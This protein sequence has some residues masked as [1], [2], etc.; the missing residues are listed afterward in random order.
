MAS[1]LIGL[2]FNTLNIALPSIVRHFHAG[3]LAA[4]W[5]LLAFMLANTVLIVVFGRFADMFGRRAMYLAGLAA[6]TG[7]SLLLGFA[8][9]AW[10]V[11]GLRVLQAAGG[12]MLLAN[13]AAI[14][15][16]VFPREQLGRAMG[17]YTAGF[18]IAQLAGP[19]LGGFLVDNFGWRWVFWFSVPVGVLCLLWGTAVLRPVEPATRERGIDV[20]GNTLVL[21]GLGGLLFGLSQVSD[22]GWSSPFVLGGIVVFVALLPVFLAVERRSPHPVVDTT[23]FRDRPF[24]LGLLATFLD[25][26]ART[27]AVL[28]MALFFQA[29]QGDDP[30]TAGLK[31]LPMAAVAVVASMGSGF[32]Q[33]RIDARTLT[34]FAAGLTTLGLVELLLT[35]SEGMAYGWVAAGLMLMGAGAGL[36]L[37]SNATALLRGLPSHRLGIVNAMRLMVLNTG[38]VVSTALAFPTITAP[39]P[40]PLREHVFAGTLAQVSEPGVH[41]LVIGYRYALAYMAVLA[42]LTVLTCLAGREP[43][44]RSAPG[45]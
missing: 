10:T 15:T 17:I 41:R 16:D 33:H 11:V 44:I 20:L 43:R 13:S 32:L 1:V 28:L 22:R 5:M 9:T 24:A 39:V 27:G 31:V 25:A 4:S 37:P 34:V 35:V 36:F 2:G 30:V 23:L 38:V 6:Y 29:A 12:A 7:A 18:S 45:G 14:L 21:A 19:T 26:A 42:A 40:A 3:P 8:P